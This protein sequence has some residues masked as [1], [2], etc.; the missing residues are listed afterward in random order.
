MMIQEGGNRQEAVGDTSE[1]AGWYGR[2]QTERNRVAIPCASVSAG[3]PFSGRSL[4]SRP[5]VR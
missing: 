4:T 5:S 2:L 3:G 1:A